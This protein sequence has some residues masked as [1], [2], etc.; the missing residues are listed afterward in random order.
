MYREILQN[1]FA[2]LGAS[3]RDDRKRIV[4][5]AEEKSL[6]LDHD[7]CQ[8]ARSDL[9]TPRTRLCAEIAWLPGVSPMKAWQLVSA[10]QSEP[11]LIRKELGL[12][13]LA[14][15]NLVAAASE[16][17]DGGNSIDDIAAFIQL[18]AS[19]VED[20]SADE[21]LRDINEDR[22]V[23]GFPEVK[24]IDQV[25]TE[26]SERKRYYR[27]AIMAV[28]KKLPTVS[29][30]DVMTVVVDGT[31][32]G[33]DYHAPEL[34]DQLVDSY[35]VEVNAFLEK[36]AQ[37]VHKLIKA[38]RDAAGLGESAIKP[39]VENLE[40]V[41]HKWDKVAQPIQ[42]S[43]KARG[44]DHEPSLEIAHSIRN[45]AID[46]FNEHGMLAV[47]Q[48]IT[49]LVKVLFVE[50][51]EVHERVEQDTEALANIFE[52]RRKAEAQRSEWASEITYRAEVG[53]IFK[54]VLSISPDGVVWKNARYPLDAI[55]RVRW[56]GVRRSVNGVPTGTDYT[57]AFGDAFSEAVVSLKNQKTYSTFTDKL[58]RAVAFRLLTELLDKLRSGKEVNFGEG[59]LRDD[60]ITLVRHKF[61]N[62]EQVR[63]LWN[64]VHFWSADGAFYIGARND[65]KTFVGLS[66]IG[67]ANTH[68][69]EQA[70]RMAFKKTGM[71]KLSEA[72]Q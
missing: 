10:L 67:T 20:L 7:A 1:P 29:L 49:G 9:N 55:T 13:T 46:L 27:A 23:S 21:V 12:P 26:L 61:W 33:G 47:S 54:D 62:K 42:L 41:A 60:G 45:L 15:L 63:F 51:P 18:L 69:V 53:L 11:M 70:M 57:V 16:A 50:L 39:F 32:S 65:K 4:E 56:G 37:N 72:L 44:I 19:L 34:I 22:I 64:E 35:G 58:W 31:T 40:K 66:Y 71:L 59:T 38:A 14:K 8:K 6:E 17:M 2:L 3:T 36:E 24:S 68:V 30:V 28:L 48:K 43:F 5:L 25:E 52:N